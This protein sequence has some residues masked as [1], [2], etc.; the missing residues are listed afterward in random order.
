MLHVLKLPALRGR[1][2]SVVQ[3]MAVVSLC[4]WMCVLLHIPFYNAGGAEGVYLPWNILAWA[5]AVIIISGGVFISSDKLWIISSASRHLFIAVLLLTVP[6][7]WCPV[8]DWMIYSLPRLAGL[9]GS[10][11]FYLALLQYRFNASVKRFFLWCVTFA[12]LIQGGTVIAGLYRPSVL[13]SVSRMF[14]V[15]G[16]RQSL[17]IFQQV[18]VTAS[19]IATGFALSLML[20]YRTGLRQSVRRNVFLSRRCARIKVIYLAALMVFLPCVLV[21]TRSR[22]GWLGGILVYSLAVANVYLVHHKKPVG[23]SCFLAQEYRV[24]MV[25]IPLMGYAA[26]LFLLR[27]PVTEALAHGDSNYQRWMTIKVTWQ[28]IKLHPWSGWGLGSFIMQ[29]QHFIASNYRPN[30]S[31]GFM[32]HPHNEILYV[33]MEGGVIA[34]TGL[35]VVCYAVIMLTLKNRSPSRRLMAAAMQPV[36]LHT[37]LEYP[38]YLSF[39]HV[40]TLLLIALNLDRARCN[41]DLKI[42][43]GWEALCLRGIVVAAC[44]WLLSGLYSVYQLNN[45]LSHFETGDGHRSLSLEYAD[46]PLLLRT[47]Y[48]AD[49]ISLLLEKYNQNGDLQ[50]LHTF[51]HENSRWLETHIDPDN[52]AGQADVLCY[53][54]RKNEAQQ[55]R[56]EGHLLFPNDERFV[57]QICR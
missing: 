17:G 35:L 22:T 41:H 36:L 28:M 4:L 9:W 16:G 12:A 20:F 13:S 53:L 5:I 10:A 45:R 40:M 52:Y 44:F 27:S 55:Y 49:R 54:H 31:H 39:P 38:L 23:R 18:N 3:I 25:L 48:E 21:L 47:R 42:N 33:W 7:F 6:V 24:A 37:M 34:L 2:L 46:V 50:L 32:G 19:F 8:H 11:V 26:G 43:T 1:K 57:G 14:L 30:P 51:I 56:Y 15:T 29:F